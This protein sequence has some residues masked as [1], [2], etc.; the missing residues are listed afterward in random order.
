MG[1]CHVITKPELGGAQLSTL[2]ILS[3]LPRDK[4]DI[5]VVTSSR[6]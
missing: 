1:V 5:F 6:G 2:S 3:R 4:Y